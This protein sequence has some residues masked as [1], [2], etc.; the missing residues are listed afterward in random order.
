VL[1]V[2]DHGEP[3]DAE[4]PGDGAS[5]APARPGAGW[6]LVSLPAEVDIANAD[7]VRADLAAALDQGC[8]VVIVDMSRTSFCDCAGV[9]VLLAA[10]SQARR[11]GLQIR[12]VARARPVLRTFELTGLYLALPV[13]PTAAD[14]ER[15]PPETAGTVGALAPATARLRR[16]LPADVG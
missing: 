15:G 5:A 4:G 11:A 7:E 14:A 13:Y 2:S 6:T 16:R 3:A 1:A 12:I 9:G 8:P 10:A